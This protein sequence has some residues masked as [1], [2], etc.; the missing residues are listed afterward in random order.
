MQSAGKWVLDEMFQTN[1][2]K[3]KLL[4]LNDLYF[5]MIHGPEHL[6]QNIQAP[7]CQQKKDWRLRAW[8]KEIVLGQ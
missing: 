3:S 5:L 7:G 8:T 2:E 1:S 4:F 6:S